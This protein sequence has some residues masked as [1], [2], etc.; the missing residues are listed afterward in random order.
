MSILGAVDTRLFVRV[1]SEFR[2]IFC[3]EDVGVLSSGKDDEL[4]RSEIRQKNTKSFS[5]QQHLV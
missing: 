3:E 1:S 2:C 5:C 4:K